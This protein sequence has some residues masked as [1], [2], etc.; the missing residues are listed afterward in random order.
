MPQRNELKAR[1]N[2]LNVGAW[3][4]MKKQIKI[5]STPSAADERQMRIVAGSMK[6]MGNGTKTQTPGKTKEKHHRVNINKAMR[7][8]SDENSQ[9]SENSFTAEGTEVM[10]AP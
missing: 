2:T 7:V 10:M 9:A 4:E 6:A 1:G 8:A 3:S 5:S